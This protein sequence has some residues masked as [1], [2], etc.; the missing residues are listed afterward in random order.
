MCV[1]KTCNALCWSQHLIP[2]AL[3]CDYTI[4]FLLV[5]LCHSLARHGNGG[6]LNLR[7]VAMLSVNGSVFVNCSAVGSG[8]TFFLGSDLAVQSSV[9]AEL[10]NATVLGS[11]AES[12]NGGAVLW[13]P[14]P[15]YQLAFSSSALVGFA[16]SGSGGGMDAAAKSPTP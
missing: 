14:T 9:Q 3:W 10:H 13:Q 2:S 8:G 15:L 12:G 11:A 7:N 5:S 16:S 4:R 6:A 1:G